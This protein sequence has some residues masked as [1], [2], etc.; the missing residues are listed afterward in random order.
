MVGI[1]GS[2]NREWQGSMFIAG[3][4]CG[5][6]VGTAIGMLC[7]PKRGADLRRQVGESADR[8]RRLATDAYAGVSHAIY[9]V[10]DR[11][12]RAV[13][14]GHHAFQTPPSG[15]GELKDVERFTSEGGPEPGFAFPE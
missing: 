1:Q 13:E 8:T 14:A 3:A 10:I 15:N 6:V 7:A 2:Q 11:S 9:D 12:R 4:L 5:A